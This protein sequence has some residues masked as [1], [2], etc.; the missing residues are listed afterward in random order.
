ME[1]LREARGQQ[2]G[3]HWF[4]LHLSKEFTDPEGTVKVEAAELEF[5]WEKLTQKAIFAVLL[6]CKAG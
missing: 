5:L 2:R 4:Q 1:G 6:T 3:S